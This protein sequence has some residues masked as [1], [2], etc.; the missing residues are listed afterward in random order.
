M[1]SKYSMNLSNQ[2]DEVD[3]KSPNKFTSPRF[4]DK[5]GTG[6]YNI[7]SSRNNKQPPS[8]SRFS[9]EAE[10]QDILNSIQYYEHENE[11]LDYQTIKLL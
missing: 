2:I 4:N 1:A 6:S 7:S 11:K 5:L 3:E 8:S 10:Y 9:P